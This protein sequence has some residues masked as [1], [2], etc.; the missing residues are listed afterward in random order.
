MFTYFGNGIFLSSS[1]GGSSLDKVSLSAAL[2][3]D[4]ETTKLTDHNVSLHL[5]LGST[6]AVNGETKTD[7]ILSLNTAIE[8]TEATEESMSSWGNFREWMS[9]EMSIGRERSRMDQTAYQQ[10]LDDFIEAGELGWK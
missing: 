8:S 10:I 1:I 2:E 6:V 3:R 5:I 7:V 9:Q 4:E